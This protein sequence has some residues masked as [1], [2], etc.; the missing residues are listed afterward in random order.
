MESFLQFCEEMELQ[1]GR[2]LLMEERAFL[3]WVFNRY[4]E[5]QQKVNV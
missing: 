5:E 3:Q 4:L 1:L 2:Q